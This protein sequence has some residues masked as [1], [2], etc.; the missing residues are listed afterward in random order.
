MLNSCL[1]SELRNTI[2]DMMK[3]D[4]T[5]M[6]YLSRLKK[7]ATRFEHLQILARMAYVFRHPQ[8]FSDPSNDDI[9]SWWITESFNTDEI[10]DFGNAA[11]QVCKILCRSD[12]KHACSRGIYMSFMKFVV[13]NPYEI[14]ILCDILDQVEIRMPNTVG[15]HNCSHVKYEYLIE[16][17]NDYD[18]K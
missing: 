9:Y 8:A 6:Y 5:L 7:R 12:I 15:V 16:L 2:N 17:V 13:L 10:S 1:T 4:T 18:L 14:N 11:L 3:K